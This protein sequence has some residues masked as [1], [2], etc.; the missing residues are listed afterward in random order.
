MKSIVGNIVTS[1]GVKF[2]IVEFD[3]GVI[4]KVR[5]LDVDPSTVSYPSQSVYIFPGFID[6][7]VICYDDVTRE[8]NYR[9]DYESLGMAALNGGVVQTI[10][11]PNKYNRIS[12]ISAF[13]NQSQLASKCPVD[14]LCGCNAYSGLSIDN[15]YYVV[16][17]NSDDINIHELGSILERYAGRDVSF[18]LGSKNY[19]DEYINV[20]VCLGII[21]DLGINAKITVSTNAALREIIEA[22]KDGVTVSSEVLIHNLYFDVTMISP[23]CKQ[24][25]TFDYPI[26]DRDSRLALLKSLKAGDIDHIASFHSPCLP[27]EKISGLLNGPQ[28]DHFGSFLCYLM[29]CHD[30]SAAQILKCVCE[31]PGALIGRLTNRKIG[32]IEEGFE[33][34][35][36]ILNVSS[37]QSRLMH[38]KAGWSV[39][40]PR[41]LPGLVEEVYVRGVRMVS[42]ELV[43]S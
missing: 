32:K 12:D 5:F 11:L 27:N 26:R 10:E 25:L 15:A 40:D 21:K 6:V 17:I 8:Y 37:T 1:E 22:K 20:L 31:N 43:G 19:E 3:N 38:T 7:A 36:T 4:E 16:N 41:C 14:V 13:D 24:Y 30:V 29:E 42:G 2:G 23:D 18:Y 39:F 34:S 35:F 33:A 9:E 28:L